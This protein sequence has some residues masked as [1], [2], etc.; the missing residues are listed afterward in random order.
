MEEGAGHPKGSL[1]WQPS[2]LDEFQVSER[3]YFKKQGG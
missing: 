2:H 1:T 3:L